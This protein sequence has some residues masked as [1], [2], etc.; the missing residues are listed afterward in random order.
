MPLV[1]REKIDDV[2]ERTNIVEVVKRHVELKRAGTGSWKG[3]CPFHSEKTP[4]FT[5]HEPRQFFHCFGCGAG[6]GFFKLIMQLESWT[7]PE[8]VRELGRRVGVEVAEMSTEERVQYDHKRT[9]REVQAEAVRHAGGELLPK[10]GRGA[11]ARPRRFARAHYVPPREATDLGELEFGDYGRD[12]RF[13][14]G[15]WILPTLFL[16]FALMIWIVS[17]LI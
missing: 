6:G 5:V 16:G 9:L 14:A 7:F 15:W 4:S 3:L 2:R 17:L 13:L 1:P 10:H 11:F 12:P 8:A